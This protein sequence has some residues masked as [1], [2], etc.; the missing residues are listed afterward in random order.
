MTNQQII[1][2]AGKS[3]VAPDTVRRWVRGDRVIPANLKA[4]ETAAA[5]LGI[6]R[7]EKTEAQS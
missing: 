7:G 6:E 5:E 4:I 2:I 3:G 1:Q